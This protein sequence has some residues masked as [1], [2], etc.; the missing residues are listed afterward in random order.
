M[1]KSKKNPKIKSAQLST[2]NFRV[3]PLVDRIVS[4]VGRYNI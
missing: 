1:V 2:G 3:V 4:N